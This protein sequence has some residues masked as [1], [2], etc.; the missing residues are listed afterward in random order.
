L[1]CPKGEGIEMSEDCPIRQEFLSYLEK[2]IGPRLKLF[3]EHAVTCPLC[4]EWFLDNKD[5]AALLNMLTM[6]DETFKRKMD[7]I[8]DK[9]EIT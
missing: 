6:D 8:A 5:D 3:L 1:L 4:R 7:E 2:E 9:G